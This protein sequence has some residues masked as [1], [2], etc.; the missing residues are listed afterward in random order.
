MAPLLRSVLLLALATHAACVRVVRGE[1][2][3]HMGRRT[4]LAAAAASALLQIPMPALAESREDKA[5]AQILETSAA[6][7]KLLDDKEAFVAAYVE[8]KGDS[9]PVPP[10]VPF[11]VFQTLEKTA[12]PEF[13]EIAIDYAEAARGAR[14]LIKLAK[15]TK[16]PVEVSIKEPGK[17]RLTQVTEYGAAKGSALASAKEYTERAVQEILAA[18]ICLDE[19]V[20]VMVAK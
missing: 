14:D 3:M 12:E 6:L 13:M 11:T 9:Y 8:G 5:R 19:A 16:K 18:S 4:T 17:P 7:H 20:K 10:T 2:A 1:Q 15:L